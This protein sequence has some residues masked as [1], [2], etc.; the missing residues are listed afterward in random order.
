V[1]T[2]DPQ[3][4]ADPAGMILR[5]SAHV[6]AGRVRLSATAQQRST[7]T[8]L[9]GALAVAPGE[10]VLNNP[11]RVALLLGVAEMDAAQSQRPAAMIQ[12]A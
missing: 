5:A 9:L 1:P 7:Q 6:H 4:L 2:I 12:F 11:L 10:A 8:P 3:A